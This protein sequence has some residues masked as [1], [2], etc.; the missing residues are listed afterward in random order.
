MNNRSSS[1]HRPADSLAAMI[2]AAGALLLLALL[3]HNHAQLIATPV[4]LDYYEGAMQQLTQLISEGSNPYTREH[5]PGSADV[6]PPLYNLLVAALASAFG[7]SLPLHRAVSGAFILASCALVLLSA[8]RAGASWPNALAAGALCYAALLFYATPIASTNAV[9]VFLFLASTLLPWFK[10]FS[11]RS[12]IAAAVLGVLGFYGKQ[13]CVAGIGYVG[14]WL[15]LRGEWRRAAIFGVGSAAL[16]GGSLAV[17]DS[18]SPF[19][20]DNTVFA[21]ANAVGAYDSSV[22][23]Y[24]QL[25][26]FCKTYGALAPILLIAAAQRLRANRPAEGHVARWQFTAPSNASAYLWFCLLLST[27]VI[28]LALGRNPGNYMTYLYQLMAPFLLAGTFSLPLMQGPRAAWL[29]PLVLFTF[30]RAYWI[31]PRDFSIDPRGWERIGA[32]IASGDH[33]L[34][35][36]ILVA[37]LVDN[38]KRVFENGHTFYFRRAT[39]KPAFF[40]T[41]NPAF[42]VAAVWEDFV[43]GMYT[44]VQT[45]RFDC[46]LANSWDLNGIFTANP[47]PG[48]TL[49]G[50]T[51]MQQF[52]RLRETVPVTMPNRPGGGKWDIQV[53]VPKNRP[54]ACVGESGRLTQLAPPA[55]S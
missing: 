32:I 8:R 52:Y 36:P 9:G 11:T 48:S 4:P 46:I 38:G 5:Q 1:A 44:D 41:K 16:L 12:L 43:R 17:V 31:L 22:Y 33:I 6:Y 53:W 34:A 2:C 42:D 28:V 35:S 40:K 15:L 23:V 37:P 30:G 3:L 51:F 27:A 55:T 54:G 24:R 45:G 10:A 29:L 19:F 49:D 50:L 26:E 21:V 25:L 47:P 18:T 39:E 14:A 7:N 20:L 13:Y